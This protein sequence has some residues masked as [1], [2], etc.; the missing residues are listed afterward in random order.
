MNKKLSVALAQLDLFVG[1]V[2]GNAIKIIDYCEK[3]RDVLKADLIVFPELALSGYPPEDLL[4]HSGY[5]RRI[6][7]SLSQIKN[8]VHGI[9]VLFGFPEYVEV[10][11]YNS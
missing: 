10:D 8:E 3:A 4:F 2:K 9:A 11:I 7:D 5:K 1:D 6:N